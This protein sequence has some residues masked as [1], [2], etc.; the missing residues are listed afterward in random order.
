MMK[1][2][3][4]VLCRKSVIDQETNNL[5]LYDVFE[6]LDVSIKSNQESNKEI[7]KINIPVEY[8]V[9]SMW[10]KDDPKKEFTAKI[11][12]EVLDPDGSV[13]KTFQ[14]SFLF[15]AGLKRMRSR[16]RV[17]GLDISTSGDYIFNLKYNNGKKGSQIVASLPL[18]VHINKVSSEAIKS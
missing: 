3:W 1:H 17:V 14:H 6:Q 12:L 18:E 5:S 16:L 13:S 7:K 4:S 9:V 15:A 10:M 2:I 8:E 11:E